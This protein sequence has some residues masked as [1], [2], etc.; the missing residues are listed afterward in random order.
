MIATE[1]RPLF[2]V[3]EPMPVIE[4][5]WQAAGLPV[6][7]LPELSL[8]GSPGP[9]LRSSFMIS[10]AAQVRPIHLPRILLT[11]QVSTALSALAASYLNELRTGEKRVVA[12]DKRAASFEFSA[13]CSLPVFMVY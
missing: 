7:R 6:D 12:V 2:A 3:F 8:T 13:S 9:E 5:I 10:E 1:T 4:R 11:R